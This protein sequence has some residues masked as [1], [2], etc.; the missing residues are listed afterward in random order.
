MVGG[1]GGGGRGRV[2]GVRILLL[3]LMVSLGRQEI[4]EEKKWNS[5]RLNR[6]Q[7]TSRF[8]AAFRMYF[9]TTSGLDTLQ[10]YCVTMSRHLQKLSLSLPIACGRVWSLDLLSEVLYLLLISVEIL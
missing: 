10:K 3:V 2:M 5:F 1:I 6:F 4:C 8:D 9:P 7:E